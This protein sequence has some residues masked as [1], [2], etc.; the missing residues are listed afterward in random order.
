MA[1]GRYWVGTEASL[2]I[3]IINMSHNYLRSALR[4]QHLLADRQRG[5]QILYCIAISISR[6]TG[7]LTRG[8]WAVLV[9][10]SLDRLRKKMT[11]LSKMLIHLLTVIIM[12]RSTYYLSYLCVSSTSLFSKPWTKSTNAVG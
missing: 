1:H 6:N 10:E 12:D 8:Q 4:R 9:Q 2:A 11:A 3:N 7:C 5:D